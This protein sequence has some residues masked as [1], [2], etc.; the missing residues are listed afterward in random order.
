MAYLTHSPYRA[1]PVFGR[2]DHAAENHRRIGRCLIAALGV[3]VAVF[4]LSSGGVP[5][6][7]ISTVSKA[8]RLVAAGVGPTSEVAASG[9]NVTVAVRHDD[10]VARVTTVSKGEV[11]GLNEGS[12]F[13]S[14]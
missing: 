6:D 8:D 1:Y 11:A 9:V 7:Q 13:A 10:R 4:A 3:S 5:A 14:R 12:P 2:R